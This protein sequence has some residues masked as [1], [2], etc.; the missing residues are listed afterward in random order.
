VG[1]EAKFDTPEKAF[2]AYEEALTRAGEN[3]VGIYRNVK[4]PTGEYIVRVGDQHSVSAPAEGSW[5]SVLHKHPNPENVL[6]RRMPAP[7][8]VHNTLLSAFRANHPITEFID[9][10]LP[11]GRRGLVAYTVEPAR[12]RVTIKYERADGTTVVRTFESVEAYASHYSERTTYVDP[13]SPEYEWMKRDLDD[14]YSQRTT[15][16]SSTATGT[17]KPGATA[18]AEPTTQPV[19]R[20]IERRPGKL[21]TTEKPTVR[22]R[23]QLDQATQALAQRIET[24]KEHPDSWAMADELDLIRRQLSEGREADAATRITGL[25][26]RVARAQLTKSSSGLTQAY[27]EPAEVLGARVIEYIPGGEEAPIILDQTSPSALD[28]TGQKLLGHVRRAVAEFESTGGLT[29][30]ELEAVRA[31]PKSKQRAMYKMYRG[32]AIDRLAKK[33]VFDDPTLEHVYVTVNKEAGADFFDSRTGHWY[34][35][36]TIGQW[37]AHQT[38]YGPTVPGYTTVPGARLPTEKE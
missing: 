32:T 19:E 3:E 36:T 11:D 5:E 33:A 8:D 13:K 16:P 7:Q 10:P 6:T 14:F 29:V 26:Q 25:E 4:S 23:A 28:A 38:K 2:G 12:G 30:G 18:E 27:G 1:G 17:L 31:A 24:L 20:V 37:S 15:S 21:P 9:Y 35:M 34:D 22:T